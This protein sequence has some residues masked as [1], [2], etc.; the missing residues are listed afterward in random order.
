MEKGTP[1]V[2]WN[3]SVRNR[4]VNIEIVFNI[5]PIKKWSSIFTSRL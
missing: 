5:L 3:N 1:K 2:I 4:T